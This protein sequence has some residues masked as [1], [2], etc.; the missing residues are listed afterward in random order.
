MVVQM[1]PPVHDKPELT[2]YGTVPDAAPVHDKP[3]LTDYGTVPDTAPC[4][5]SL[6]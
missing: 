3:E 5:T 2:D 6:S 1:P 4:M